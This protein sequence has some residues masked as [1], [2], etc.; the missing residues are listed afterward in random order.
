MKTG[1]A[2]VVLLLTMCWRYLACPT[3]CKCSGDIVSCINVDLKVI[4]SDIP[5]SIHVLDV[6][7]N[8]Q[9]KL[10]IDSLLKFKQL[11]ILKIE[12]CGLN[13][14]VLLPDSLTQAFLSKNRLTLDCLSTMFNQSSMRQPNLQYLDLH[15]NGIQFDN[16]LNALPPSLKFLILSWNSLKRIGP[17]DFQ[18]FRKLRTLEMKACDISNIAKDAFKSLPYL[19]QLTI[20]SN[21]IKTLPLGSFR[22]NTKLRYLRLGD[23]ELESI[24]DLRGIPYLLELDVSRNRLRNVTSEDISMRYITSLDLHGNEITFFNLSKTVS[25]ELD[26]SFN[27]LSHIDGMV[28]GSKRLRYVF[29]HKNQIKTVSSTAF[30]GVEQVGELYLHKNQIKYLPPGVFRGIGIGKLVLYGN[31]LANMTGVLKSMKRPPYLL[32][33]FSNPNLQHLKSSDYIVMSNTSSLYLT[34]KN[35][36]EISATSVLK[37]KIKCVPSSDYVITTATRAL[38]N[39]GYQCNYIGETLSFHCHPCTVGMTDACHDFY[40]TGKC[41]QCPPGS[42]YQDEVASTACKK[43]PVGQYVPPEKAPGKSPLDCLTCPK[44]TDT[45]EL[46]WYRACRCLPGYARLDRF[47]EC[48]KCSKAGIECRRD[49]PVLERGYWITW[50]FTEAKN[51]STHKQSCKQAFRSFMKNLDTRTNDYDRQTTKFECEIPLPQK[52]PIPGSC[53]GGID[54]NCSAGY[55]D[56]LCAVCDEGYMKDMNKCIRCPEPIIAILKLIGYF[57]I[58]I[59]LCFLLSWIDGSRKTRN[60]AK[61][62]EHVASKSETRNIADIILSSLKIILGFYQVLGGIISAMSKTPWP[63]ELQRAASY[64]EYLEFEIF[65][66]PSLRCIKHSWTINAVQEF[67]LALIVTA[68]FPVLMLLYAGIKACCIHSD[69]KFKQRMKIIVRNCLRSVALFL[70]A[71]YPITSRRIARVLPMSC[72]KVC[73]NEL[74]GRCIKHIA[75]LR[76][77][78]SVECLNIAPESKKILDSAYVA[79][80]IPFGLPFLLLILLWIFAPKLQSVVAQND[81]TTQTQ[82]NDE[83]QQDDDQRDKNNEATPVRIDSD[84]DVTPMLP[85]T[86]GNDKHQQDGKQLVQNNE[87]TPILLQQRNGKQHPDEDQS[88]QNNEAT[89]ILP[90]QSNGKQHPDDD[91]SSQNNEATPILSQQSNDKQHPDDNQ[92]IQSNEATPFLPQQSN[93]KQHPDDNQLIQSNEATPILPQQINDKQQS[94]DNQSSQSDDDE[95]E[96]TPLLLQT[97]SNLGQQDDSQTVQNNETTLLLQTHSNNKRQQDD[98][99]PD[100]ETTPLQRQAQSNVKQQDRQTVQNNETIVVQPPTNNSDTEGV[101]QSALRFAYENYEASCWYWEVLEMVRKLLLTVGIV[102]FLEHTK[103]GLGGIIVIAMVF[104]VLHAANKPIKDK[105]ENFAQLLSLS[106]IPVNLAIGAVLQSHEIGDKGIIEESKDSWALGVL[107]VVLNSLVAFLIVCRLLRII[108]NKARCKKGVMF[109]C[110]CSF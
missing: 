77:D 58:F 13:E 73:T 95:S 49:Y 48:T 83:Q 63:K 34:C 68:C 105:F 71:T 50:N 44:G 62:D 94:D 3:K 56:V 36:K 47:G 96:T 97:Q 15:S 80:L 59:F 38:G 35:L 82:I 76:S 57:F 6:S 16:G 108:I 93:D 75:Y 30:S 46:A 14:P 100:N 91:Q 103:V 70:F 98:D 106:I 45:G 1:V 55:R 61:N 23:N 84:S 22:S 88:S 90:Q 7:S 29:L 60:R 53:L 51:T 107:L 99:Q 67:E 79:L 54:A 66:I 18:Q 85:Q 37:A 17:N 64:M 40:C 109:C 110:C 42:F 89:P 12:N 39:D 25:Y 26:L 102:F 74:N 20:E 4:P 72:H 8:P 11:Q 5:I 65:R 81:K 27:R 69:A 87:T 52:C 32:L 31:D 92:L 9:L 21:P 28:F 101:A 10:R 19:H 41:R 33:L 78:Y 24:P 43:C 2:V 86:Q 104:T